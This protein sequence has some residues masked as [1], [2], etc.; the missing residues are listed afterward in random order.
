MLQKGRL[1]IYLH[2]RLSTCGG[3]TPV[4]L[5]AQDGLVFLALKFIQSFDLR[6]NGSGP[7][8]PV[9]Q[10]KYIHINIL[11]TCI[12]FINFFLNFVLNLELKV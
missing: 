2:M 12:V 11:S 8:Q 7:R 6:H 5:F 4:Q 1:E 3:G 9:S 10:C